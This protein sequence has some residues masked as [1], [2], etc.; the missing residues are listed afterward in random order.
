MGHGLLIVY[1]HGQL[2]RALWL[3]EPD[4]N[5][6]SLHY[7]ISN[8]IWSLVMPRQAKKRGWLVPLRRLSANQRKYWNIWNRIFGEYLILENT[9]QWQPGTDVVTGLLKFCFFSIH[10]YNNWGFDWL[11]C[12]RARKKIHG[13]NVPILYVHW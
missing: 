6:F 10:I 5:T 9:K 3:V 2:H 7:V 13:K 12:W 8:K 1:F 11:W 4:T